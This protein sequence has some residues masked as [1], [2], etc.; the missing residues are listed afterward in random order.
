MTEL[1][2]DCDTLVNELEQDS[3]NRGTIYLS[4]VSETFRERLLRQ[5]SLFVGLE[6]VI[7][8]KDFKNRKQKKYSFLSKCVSLKVALGKESGVGPYEG[9]EEMLIDCVSG[10][11]PGQQLVILSSLEPGWADP[12][13]VTSIS[14]P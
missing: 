13:V 9:K 10:P 4:G 3:E 12:S 7:L 2:L 14:G 5:S 11:G 6:A 8:P 1:T